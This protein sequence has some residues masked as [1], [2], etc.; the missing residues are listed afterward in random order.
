[1]NALIL[2][3]YGKPAEDLFADDTLANLRRLM[4]MGAF[5]KVAPVQGDVSPAGY[6]NILFL[7]KNRPMRSSSGSL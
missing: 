6:V 4:A 1:M 2:V 5:G 3:I 7:E